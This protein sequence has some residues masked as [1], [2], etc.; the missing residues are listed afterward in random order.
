M[1][2]TAA[3]T[4]VTDSATEAMEAD[5]AAAGRVVAARVAVSAWVAVAR[6][7]AAMLEADVWEAVKRRRT[8][9]H[10]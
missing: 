3:A 8:C 9:R 1:A 7:A 2:T 5:L 4:A 6:A 10:S